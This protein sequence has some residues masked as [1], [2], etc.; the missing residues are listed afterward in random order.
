MNTQNEKNI[1]IVDDG[2]DNLRLI[3]EFL[4]ESK[5][6]YD[7]TQSPDARIALELIERKKP[8]L[9]ITDWEMPNMDGIEFIKTLKSNQQT[10]DI[11]V[12]MCTGVMTTSENLQTALNAGAIDFVRKPIDK[13]ELIARTHSALLLAES[14]K[15]IIATNKELEATNATKDKFFSIIAHDLK[16]PFNSMLGFGQ[17]LKD[18]L[19][20]ENYENIKEFVNLMY[21]S[22]AD[23]FK[24]LENLLEWARMQ[25]GKIKFAPGNFSLPESIQDNITLLMQNARKKDIQLSSK[26]FD[27]I[28][29][30]ADNNMINTVLRNLI[31]NAIK[32]TEQGGSIT[33]ECRKDGDMAVVRVIDTGIGIKAEKIDKLFKLDESFT[34]LGTE[35]EKGTGLGLTLCKEFIEKHNGT[36]WVESETGKGSS[37][38]FTLPV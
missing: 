26:I 35:N 3:V 16:T 1:L 21:D 18:N 28:K 12:I 30:F 25:T 19:K 8:D 13:V 14:Y 27:R 4:V 20:R 37:F 11:P 34:T 10:K 33:V 23:G 32:F 36:I 9:I 24:L 15:Q 2:L 22:A 38:C 6:P 31:S 17:I 29:V 7:I 5:L